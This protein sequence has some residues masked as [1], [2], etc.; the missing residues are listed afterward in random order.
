MPSCLR[1]LLQERLAAAMLDHG[2][3]VD[4]QTSKKGTTAL[5]HAAVHGHAAIVRRLLRAGADI[6]LR[7]ADGRSA[8]RFATEKGH[9]ECV[10]AIKEHVAAAARRQAAGG[11]FSVA[12]TGKAGTLVWE[13]LS[14]SPLG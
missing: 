8:L 2:A 13:G 14:K 6:K 4:L 3:S 7:D 9:A 12:R 1:R 11:R 5:M 10:A